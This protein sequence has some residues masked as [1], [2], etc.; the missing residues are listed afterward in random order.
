MNELFKSVTENVTFVLEFL[1]VIVALFVVAL[2]LEK[3]AQ[4]KQGVSEKIFTTR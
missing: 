1:V 4:K 2:L 3:L